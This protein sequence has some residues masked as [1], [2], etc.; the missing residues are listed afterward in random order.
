MRSHRLA[1]KLITSP[2]NLD[3]LRARTIIGRLM[4]VLLK[5]EQ[6]NGNGEIETDTD[7]MQIVAGVAVI[8]VCG[9]VLINVPE[10][11][12]EC[13]DICD[14]NEI[15]ENVEQALS[16]Q[17]VQMI[18][19]NVD[20]PGGLA[21]AG[22]KLFD[23]IEAAN[24]RKPCYGFCADGCD[25][26]SAAYE[27]VAACRELRAGY[28]ADGIG[29]IGSYLAYLDD[30]EFWAQMGITFEVFRSGELK[31]IGESVPLT[32]AQRDYLQGLVDQ[33]GANIRR[34]VSKYRTE[35]SPDDMQGQWFDGKTAAQRGFIAACEKDLASA[36]RAFQGF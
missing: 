10:W 20:S 31:G 11:M 19:F 33:F 28:Y 12:T 4:G 5:N 29:C 2:W 26:A 6:P 18:V 15:Q 32:Q 21:I 3:A 17:N 36:V 22:D 35:I 7:E 1:I 8:P 9:A 25:M 30:T 13:L 24:Q 27:A 34:N 16:D 23:V 14:A